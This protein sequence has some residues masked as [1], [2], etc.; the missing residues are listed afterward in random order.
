V[1]VEVE[2]HP[3]RAASPIAMTTRNILVL[4]IV[5]PLGKNCRRQV[6]ISVDRKSIDTIVE[7]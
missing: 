6:E 1:W 5:E 7:T 3:A 2:P 4:G